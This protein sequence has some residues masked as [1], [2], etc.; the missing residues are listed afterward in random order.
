MNIRKSYRITATLALLMAGN[1]AFAQNPS[2]MDQPATT[3]PYGGQVDSS[4][5]P[6]LVRDGVYDRVPHINSTLT[7]QPVREV[8]ILWKKRVWREIDT[9]EKQNIGFRFA[10]DENS[11]GGYFIEIL[12]DAIKRGKVK[13]YSDIDDRFT[14]PLTKDQLMEKLAIKWD[15]SEVV[16]PETQQTEIRVTKR[17]FDPESITKYRIKEDWVFDRNL[18]KMVVRIIGL[19]PM[20]DKKSESTGEYIGS[21][22]MFWLYY[23]ELRD[24]LAQYEVVNPDND[25]H[26]ITWDDFF[27]QRQFSSKIIKMSNPLDENYKTERLNDQEALYKGQAAA[28]KIFNKEHDMWVY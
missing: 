22:A 11:G 9:R 20:K 3:S 18:G 8:D 25:V 4:W 24:V 14:S 16:N 13:A 23:P 26:R 21:S 15:T 17:E 10:G 5:R 12:I 1:M 27:E 28:E 2:T 19:A 7:W 6:S